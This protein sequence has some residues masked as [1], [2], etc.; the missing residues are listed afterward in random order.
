MSLEPAYGG[1]NDKESL[2]NEEKT[3]KRNRK[4]KQLFLS[5]IGDPRINKALQFNQAFEDN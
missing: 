4:L 5:S 2:P 3:E 1:W